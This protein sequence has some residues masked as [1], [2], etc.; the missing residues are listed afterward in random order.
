MYQLEVLIPIMFSDKRLIGPKESIRRKSDNQMEGDQYTIGALDINATIRAYQVPFIS[1][2]SLVRFYILVY[3][4]FYSLKDTWP[5]DSRH[6]S[7]GHT[8]SG[9]SEAAGHREPATRDRGAAASQRDDGGGYEQ[10]IPDRV[11]NTYRR[12]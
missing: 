7:V 1:C 2:E 8:E 9:V 6:R 4:S 11:S 12:R 3:Q 5:L 10:G